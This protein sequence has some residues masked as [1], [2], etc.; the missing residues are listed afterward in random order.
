MKAHYQFTVDIT[1][2]SMNT[3][4][5]V[6]ATDREAAVEKAKTHFGNSGFQILDTPEGFIASL[7]PNVYV[8]KVE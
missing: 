6:I 3:H 8:I 2:P 4:T 1:G 5:E 7:E